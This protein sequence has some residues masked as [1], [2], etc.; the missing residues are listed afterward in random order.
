MQTRQHQHV[1]AAGPVGIADCQVFHV[2]A[3]RGGKQMNL[4]RTADRY[5][6]VE[7]VRQHAAQGA[8]CSIPV[9][10]PEAQDQKQQR[11]NDAAD[12]PHE[13]WDTIEKVH[14]F[15]GLSAACR[16]QRTLAGTTGGCS[17]NRPIRSGLAGAV[18]ESG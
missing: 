17:R 14:F 6:P 18:Q 16:D 11:D 4:Q 2:D 7:P 13:P 9:N 15:A 12:P 10:Q 5:L 1:S 3:R 8:A